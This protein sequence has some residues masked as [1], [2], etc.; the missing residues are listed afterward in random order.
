LFVKLITRHAEDAA[1][2]W[3]RFFEGTLASQHDLRSLTRFEF[4]LQGNLEGL[5]VAQQESS[6]FDPEGKLVEAG[7]AGWEPA[8]KRLT[9]WK[10]ADEAFVCSVL[11]L[12]EAHALMP[13]EDARITGL[14]SSADLPHRAKLA[15]IEQMACQQFDD[16]D[17]A[18]D[19]EIARGLASAAAWVAWEKVQAVVFSWANSAH[20]VLRRCALSAC[21]LP[22]IP[23]GEALAHWVRDPHGLVR[24][25]AMRAAG[26]LGRSDL[27]PLL[28][29][30]LQ[31]MNASY[32]PTSAPDYW[33]GRF[34]A[35]WSLCLLGS[36]VGA[37]TL[38]KILLEQ[39]LHR[40]PDLRSLQGWS[41]L[42]QV[43]PLEAQQSIANQLLQLDQP[44]HCWRHALAL[45]RF[46]GHASWLTTLLNM[47]RYEYQPE[48]LQLYFQEPARNLARL[49]ADV[50]AHITGARI[51]EQL[52]SHPP[53]ESEETEQDTEN[54]NASNPR[55]PAS[56]KQDPDDALLWPDLAAV[57]QWAQ[58]HQAKWQNTGEH[59][60]C[61][62]DGNALTNVNAKAIIANP[63]STQL[64]RHHAAL[65]L[66]CTDQS[67]VLINVRQSVAAQRA[68]YS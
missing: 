35:A 9:K 41:A 30:Q 61:Y 66:R 56:R 47:M 12:E 63:L 5:R 24:A 4:L 26:E 34:W 1:F 40:A 13:D 10:T 14:Q 33:H 43:M 3:S 8:F 20:P 16:S 48:R 7:N 64:Q 15:Q 53:E 54:Q 32:H 55:L 6:K 57:Q 52:W 44:A 67:P 65:F 11:A 23:A 22:R 58:A 28:I 60:G 25:R 42:A 46:S 21:A 29:E 45:I 68:N 38:L 51:G 59:Q 27:V 31:S 62:L 18:G 36:N 49:A 17:G 50:F 37:D 39:A 19:V 2:Y